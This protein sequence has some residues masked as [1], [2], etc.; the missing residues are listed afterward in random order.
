MY[1]NVKN[2][3]PHHSRTQKYTGD[4]EAMDEQNGVGGGM[5]NTKVINIDECLVNDSDDDEDYKKSKLSMCHKGD[6]N[7]NNINIKECMVQLAQHILVP[8]FFS[9]LAMTLSYT[10]ISVFSCFDSIRIY[11]LFVCEYSLLVDYYFLF[12]NNCANV[13]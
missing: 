9:L 12:P 1:C 13:T 11:C 8:M 7:T 10:S 4:S 6:E 5:Q 2:W 3:R